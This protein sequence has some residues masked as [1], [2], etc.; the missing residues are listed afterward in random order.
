MLPHTF[1]VSSL[2]DVPFDVFFVYL[3]SVC[4]APMALPVRQHTVIKNSINHT[5][6][7]TQRGETQGM[8]TAQRTHFKLTGV[9]RGE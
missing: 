9:I 5:A 3:F 4:I 7:G 8:K 6:C 1:T 2:I